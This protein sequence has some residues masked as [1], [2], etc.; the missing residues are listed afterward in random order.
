MTAG[1]ESTLRNYADAAKGAD[2]YDTQADLYGQMLETQ[3]QQIQA[4]T[5]AATAEL[6]QQTQQQKEDITTAYGQSDKELFRNYRNAVRDLPQQLAAMGIT[7]GLSESSRVELESGY[8]ENL[9]KSQL[10]RMA[11]IADLDA[12][13]ATAQRQNELAA[14]QQQN[15][16]LLEYYRNLAGLGDQRYQEQLTDQ[17][18]QDE[19]EYAEQRLLDEREY[20]A[21]REAAELERAREEQSAELERARAEQSAEILASIGD[22]SGYVSLGLMSEEQAKLMKQLWNAENPELAQKLGYV[23]TSSSGRYYGGKEKTTEEAYGELDARTKAFVDAAI[24]KGSAEE[25]E[26]YLAEAAER[27]GRAPEVTKTAYE[28]A[29]SFINK[30]LS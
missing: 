18:L 17:R 13:A 19:R 27:A 5:D 28:N 30:Y 24:S 1:G 14:G 9:N 10:Q 2:Y 16:A 12:A 3:K 29:V 25:A 4:E 21:E 20:T 23:S 26:K 11:E 8:G 7:G 15:T 22:F 6:L